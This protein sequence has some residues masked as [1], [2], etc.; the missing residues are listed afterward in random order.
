M[1]ATAAEVR[2][3]QRFKERFKGRISLVKKD[4]DYGVVANTRVPVQKLPLNQDFGQLTKFSSMDVSGNSNAASS[5][6]ARAATE[7]EMSNGTVMHAAQHQTAGNFR[8]IQ[9]GLDSANDAIEPASLTGIGVMRVEPRQGKFV[10]VN[11][12][13]P[14]LYEAR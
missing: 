7:S 6:C 12:M 3:S 1:K 10:I 8:T 2:K 14:V 4:G 13:H 5:Q 9:L 11:P